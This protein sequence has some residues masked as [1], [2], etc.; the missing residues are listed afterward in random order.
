MLRKLTFIIFLITTMLSP[1]LQAQKVALVLSGGGSKGAAHIGV[2]RAL[3]EN[4]IPINYIVGTSIG[5]IIGS[6]Y[7]S[8]YTPDEMEKL[9]D[10]D[11]F[12]RWAGG[13]T[14]DANI[15]YYRK[16]EP[17]GGWVSLDFDFKKKL[18]SQLPT[19]LISPYEMDFAF[20]QILGPASAV[21]NSNFDQLMIP[22]RCVVSDVDSTKK[23]V[24]GKGDLSS[25]VRGSMSIPFVYKPIMINGKLVFDGGMYDNFPTDVA[26]QE[27]HPNVIIGSRVAERYSNPDR[28]DVVSQLLSML[29]AR[30]SDSIPYPNSVLIAPNIPHMNLIT[31]TKSHELAD[32]GYRAAER[33]IPDIRKLVRDSQEINILNQERSDFHKKEAAI[34]FDSIHITGLNPAQTRY[35]IQIL[36]HGKRLVS[37]DDL[38]KQ[39]F[40][41]IN[42]GFIKGIHP[43]AR[44]NPVTGYYDLFLDI[45]KAENFNL[46]FGGNVSL[47]ANSQGFLEL[48]Y[49][50][51]WTKALRFMIN[52][53]AGRFYNSVKANGRIDFNS[54][55]P[56]YIETGYTYNHYDYFATTTY[57]FD[58]KTPSYVRQREYFGDVRIGMALTNKGKLYF[59]TT[60]AF[61]NSKY[62]QNNLF[63]RLDTADQTSF[64]FV[65]P[66]LC[67]ELNNLNRK[68][69]ANA[70]ACFNFA[71][72]YVNGEEG[73][74]PGSLALNRK[75]V[76]ADQYWFYLKLLYDNYFQTWGPIK[77]GLYTEVHISNQPLMS[78][79]TSTILNI[80]DF[81]PV[82]EM[83]TLMIPAYRATSFAGFGLKGVVRLYKKIDFRLEGYVFQPYQE[84]NENSLDQTAFLGPVLSYRAWIGSA[85][86]VYNSLIGP[87][88]L[89]VNYYDKM[90]QHVTVNVNIGYILFNRKALP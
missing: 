3:E 13:I 90:A 67:F 86:L 88:S 63:T 80:P 64:N 71:V 42:E 15:Y 1:N 77:F 39:Y 20:L 46:Q 35:V 14:D 12:Q 43:I 59:S 8:G 52:G 32:S 36:K 47:G 38:K 79:Y 28:E 73:F 4:H 31:F 89:G 18:T 54:K 2:I 17:N 5:A 50:Y 23:L 76:R 72:G 41:F 66:Q 21:C 48:Q 51:L 56:W 7:A 55:V 69:Y 33:K 57:F 9:M 68:Q 27:F 29:M 74:L 19:N 82:P 87:I 61:N 26:F 83:Q 81:H 40:R 75:E 16:E 53:Y 85:S 70:G 11:A 49:K 25:A 62:Y 30:Q 60:Y 45:Q 37:S 10:S 24:L 84:I 22:F 44:F 6:L 65:N 34:I 78:N 58:D